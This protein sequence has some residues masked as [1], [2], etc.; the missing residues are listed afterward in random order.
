MN[1]A[2]TLCLNEYRAL[3]LCDIEQS[4]E[5]ALDLACTLP[6]SIPTG[7]MAYGNL[8][9][10]TVRNC[11]VK[12]S[13]GCQKCKRQGVLYDR[14][15]EPLRVLCYDN[16]RYCEIHNP[17]PLFLADR[18]PEL[19]FAAFLSLYFVDETPEQCAQVI[20][21]YQTGAKAPQ[22]GFTRGHCYKHIP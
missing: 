2:N 5:M 16:K 10:M 1:M 13:I 20:H 18:L 4:V 15:K 3:G 6:Q 19:S 17:H 14:M 11:P 7:M 22:S 21:A 12:A 8:P 9:L